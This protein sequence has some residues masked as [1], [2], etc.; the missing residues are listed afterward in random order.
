MK[1]WNSV[2]GITSNALLLGGVGSGYFAVWQ[3]GFWGLPV[4]IFLLLFFFALLRASYEIKQERDG[5]EERLENEKKRAVLNDLLGEA[6]E[7]GPRAYWSDE[8]GAFGQWLSET[9]SLIQ[10]AFGKGEAQ[11]FLSDEGF[12]PSPPAHPGDRVGADFAASR[13]V[14]ERE[15]GYRLRRLDS[16]IQR[17]NSLSIRPGFDPKDWGA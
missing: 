11:L 10:A 2:A 14:V 15:I 1:N 4:A 17:M 12:P 16:L 5:L 7:E 3:G 9:Q 13:H 6:R 8:H